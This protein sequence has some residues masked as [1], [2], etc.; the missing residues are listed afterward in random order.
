VAELMSPRISAL[1]AP[2]LCIRKG[3]LILTSFARFF[4]LK[5]MHS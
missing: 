5:F 3:G 1:S 2:P 4:C